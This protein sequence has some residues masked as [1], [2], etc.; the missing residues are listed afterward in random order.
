MYGEWNL[1]FPYLEEN[2]KLYNSY[3]KLIS[4]S[5]QTMELN[6]QN[7]LTLFDIEEDKFIFC[8]NVQNPQESLNKAVEPLENIEDEKIFKDSKVFINIA[9][10]SPEKGQEKLI[11]AFQQV[12]ISHPEARLINLGSGPFAEHL[13]NVIKELDLQNRVFFL[14][15]RFNPYPYLQKADCFIL[16]SN[17]E[18]QPMTLFEALIL[19]KP[20]IATDIVGNRSV[21]DGRPG[22][23]VENSEEGLVNGMLDFL[24]GRYIENRVFDYEGYN[25]NAL[26]MFYKKAL[27]ELSE[28][29]K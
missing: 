9:R 17:H 14:G 10:L 1:R 8:D 2:F 21:L 7:L 27:G 19:K 24:E 5:K 13:N 3:Q 29:Y 23:L 6:S 11:R 15:Q 16:S 18:G 20:I 26:N 25:Q 28:V 22:L 12:A 4:V